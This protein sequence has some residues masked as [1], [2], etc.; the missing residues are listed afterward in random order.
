MYEED[1]DRIVKVLN[2]KLKPEIKIGFHSHNNQQL[3]YALTM[4]FIKLLQESERGI[5]VDASLCGMGRGAGNATTE[6]V[7]NYLNNRC[8]KHYDMDAIM[9]AID[10]YMTYFQEKYRW[11]YSTPYFIAGNYQ[12]HVNNIAYLLDNHRTKAKD[13]RNIISSLSQAE[14]RK[15]DYDLLEQKYLNN[16]NLYIDDAKTLAQL[17]EQ[18]ADKNILLIAPGATSY[19]QKAKINAYIK[20]NKPVVIA[21]NA[22]LDGYDY[23]YLFFVN[24]ARYEYAKSAYPK[25]FAKCKKIVLSNIKNQADENEAIVGFNNVIK[26]GWRYFDNAAICA[27]RLMNMLGIEKV[28]IAGFD[29]FKTRY[30]ESYAD[31]FL[32]SL[33]PGDKWE[34]INREISEMLENLAKSAPSLKKIEF[35][36]ESLFDSRV[37]E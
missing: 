19:T 4:H 22:I 2:D 25:E 33:N 15:Y 11:G 13:M 20:E 5:V 9:D 6:L 30:N 16:R 24:A 17:K 34:N 1:L 26:R 35:V 21:V 3:S 12:C 31:Q 29:G 7:V 14:R 18:F 32:P 28:A 36:T 37:K 8:G 27:L 10:I 23:D